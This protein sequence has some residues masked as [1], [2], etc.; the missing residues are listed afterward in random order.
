MSQVLLILRDVDDGSGQVA[1]VPFGSAHVHEA[2]VTAVVPL[3]VD[4]SLDTL[5]CNLLYF[6]DAFLFDMSAVCTH[7]RLRHG[8]A[9]KAFALRREIQKLLFSYKIRV[10]VLHSEDTL[11][12][13]TRLVENNRVDLCERLHVV[14]AFDEDTFLGCTADASEERQ[15]NRYYESTGAGYNEEYARPYKPR[16]PD[17]PTAY[18]ENNGRYYSKKQSRDNYA[19]RVP[20]CEL[21]DEVLYLR[22]LLRGILHEL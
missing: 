1:V 7:D 19:G 18:A 22:F 3:A 8:M 21:R 14:C 20:A 12:K 16:L 5:A 4:D 17:I 6:A 13:R 2:A 15:R 10:Y 9:R 11:R